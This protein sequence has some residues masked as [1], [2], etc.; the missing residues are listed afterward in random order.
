MDITIF[1]QTVTE[2]NSFL[3]KFKHRLLC[4]RNQYFVRYFKFFKILLF[5]LVLLLA[6]FKIKSSLI[7]ARVVNAFKYML[8]V[9]I[10]IYV[11]GIRKN[12]EIERERERVGMWFV[13]F[14]WT[15][16]ISYIFILLFVCIYIIYTHP[17]FPYRSE[18]F[19][20]AV[21]NTVGMGRTSDACPLKPDRN[22]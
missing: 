14:K 15:F 18:P 22:N 10:Y 3:S 19:P 11:L 2:L 12:N 5:D 6:A 20:V 13:G 16:G 17:F 4:L 7:Y 8:L 9:Y 1:Y 21:G